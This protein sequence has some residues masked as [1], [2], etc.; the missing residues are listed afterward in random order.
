MS[1][2]SLLSGVVVTLL[3]LVVIAGSVSAQ[4]VE[5][6]PVV[7]KVIDQDTPGCTSVNDSFS[8][9]CY[10]LPKAHT[11]DVVAAAFGE[12]LPDGYSVERLIRSNPENPLWQNATPDTVL[13]PGFF[14]RVR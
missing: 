11:L 13:E 1:I 10:K 8:N 14:F 12:N 9:V 3:V 5:E 4:G 2:R 7:T 6:K